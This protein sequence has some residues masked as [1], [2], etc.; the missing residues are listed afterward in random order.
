V[1]ADIDVDY[2]TMALDE[3]TEASY[4]PSSP[5]VAG[6]DVDVIVDLD[7]IV[8]LRLTAAKRHVDV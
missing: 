1:L 2:A 7:S 3:R 6:V 5:E 8:E 4:P